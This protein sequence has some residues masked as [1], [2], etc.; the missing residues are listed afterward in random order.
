MGKYIGSDGWVHDDSV[1]G[2]QRYTNKEGVFGPAPKKP[3]TNHTKCPNCQLSTSWRM[4]EQQCMNCGWGRPK[5]DGDVTAACCAVMAIAVVITLIGTGLGFWLGGFG[6]SLVGL[7][8]SL[9]T[10]FGFVVVC[11]FMASGPDKVDESSSP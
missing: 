10:V 9:A 2:P 6:G 11:M 7:G 4:M 3:P 1:D 5:A 8:L